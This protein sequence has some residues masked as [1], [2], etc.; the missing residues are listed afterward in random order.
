M[1][2]LKKTKK[3]KTR[4]KDIKRTPPFA[5]GTYMYGKHNFISHSHMNM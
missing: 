4:F 5:V 2:I 1:R 3:K